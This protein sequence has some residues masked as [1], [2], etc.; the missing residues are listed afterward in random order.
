MHTKLDISLQ[1]N[2]QSNTTSMISTTHNLQM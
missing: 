2:R 1:Q